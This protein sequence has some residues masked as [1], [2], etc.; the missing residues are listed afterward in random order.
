MTNISDRIIQETSLTGEFLQ[1]FSAKNAGIVCRGT[2]ITASYWNV[3]VNHQANLSRI[4]FWSSIGQPIPT[5]LIESYWENYGFIDDDHVLSEPRIKWLTNLK[6]SGSIFST[7]IGGILARC[8]RVVSE[9]TIVSE[10][11]NYTVMMQNQWKK[12]SS[13]QQGKMLKVRGSRTSN[14]DSRSSG[15]ELTSIYDFIV[16][17]SDWA[18]FQQLSK[19]YSKLSL[20]K[21]GKLRVLLPFE[22]KSEA[23]NYATLGS[24]RKFCTVSSY[25]FRTSLHHPDKPE[26]I[27]YNERLLRNLPVNSIVDETTSV[28]E[29][30][31]HYLVEEPYI[32]GILPQ[33]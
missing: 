13:K 4:E 33:K 11:I 24:G 21:L 15:I 27:H 32:Y 30:P 17:E 31:E 28:I 26:N 19:T 3:Y 25:S 20:K 7:V 14:S 1:F 6:N 9:S 18:A 16:P 22:S 29:V 23:E 12:D 10:R 2:D 8:D 5:F